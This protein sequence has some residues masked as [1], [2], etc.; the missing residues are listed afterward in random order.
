M[1]NAVDRPDELLTGAN[2]G[3]IPKLIESNGRIDAS[4][5]GRLYEAADEFER[6]LLVEPLQILDLYLSTATSLTPS[7]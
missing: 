4:C 5:H 3:R 2:D 7:G 6:Q 1:E